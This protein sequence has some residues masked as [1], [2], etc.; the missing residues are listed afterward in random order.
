MFENQ[1]RGP[2]G[3]GASAVQH[4]AEDAPQLQR[5]EDQEGQEDVQQ[6]PDP[7]RRSD[8]AGVASLMSHWAEAKVQRKGGSPSTSHIHEAA[9]RGTSGSAGS[10]PYLAQIQRSFGPRHDVSGVQAFTGGNAQEACQSMNAQAYAFGNKIAFQ[11]SPDVHTAAHEA[12]HAIQQRAGVSLAGGVGQVG[13]K[14][15][16]HADAVADRVAQGK[17]ASGLLDQMGGGAR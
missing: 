8:G 7:A 5:H 11:R 10:L 9:E 4:R 17:D 15:E 6:K 13:D 12:A 2:T 1:Q 3:R 16:R 14:Y